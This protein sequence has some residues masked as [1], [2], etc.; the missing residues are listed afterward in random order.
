V[1]TSVTYD[2]TPSTDSAGIDYYQIQITNTQGYDEISSMPVPGFTFA[3]T[4]VYTQAV[5]HYARVRAIDGNGNIGPWSSTSAVVQSDLVPPV[6]RLPN[7]A[8]S[9]VYLYPSGLTL[10]YTNTMQFAESF[11]VR[12]LSEDNLSGLDR[13]TFSLAFGQV[14]GDDP[15]PVVFEGTYDVPNGSTE[16]GVISATVYDLVG[17]TSVQTYTYE[18]DAGLP[19]STPS[20]PAYYTNPS[21]P[22][23][24]TW[25]ATDT[26]SGVYSTTLWYMK[27]TTG[28]WQPYQTLYA[29]SGTF[30]FTPPAGDG[31]YLFAT[32]AADNVRNMEPGPVASETQTIYDTQVPQSQVTW[33]PQ[34]LNSSPITMTW[35]ATPFIASLVEVRLWYRVDGGDWQS[36]SIT[37]AQASGV[38][39]FTPSAGENAYHFGTVALDA[40]AKVEAQPVGTG[41]ATV[42]YDTSNAPP[43]GLAATPAGWTNSNDFALTW[44]NP[45]DLSGIAGAYYRLDT[46]PTYP[47]HGTR[48]D[49][50]DLEQ[51]TGVS[52]V[53]EGTHTAW[54]WLVDR[55]GNI[56]HTASSTAV[57]S[58]D[59]SI[60]AP[61]SLTPSPP[62]WTNVNS[63]AVEWTNPSDL[64][65][66]S[67]AYYKLYT[68]PTSPNDGT[69]VAG[70]DLAQ[71]SNVTLGTA[72][73]H[74]L[75]L[76][77]TDTAGNASHTMRQATTLRYD[78][79]P[80][81][82]LVVVAPSSTIETH[83]VVSWSASDTL[84]GIAWYTVEYSGT[85]YDDWQTW[86]VSTTATSAEFI[87]PATDVE[88]IFRV[89]AY[90]NA[91][92]STQEEA[93]T[94]VG[95]FYVYLPANIRYWA[96]WYQYDIYEP[97]DSPE[98]AYGPV[99]D[100][101]TYEAYIW[102]ATDQNDYY[103]FVSSTSDPVEVTLTNI[104]TGNDYDL[105]I[106][107]YT[108]KYHLIDFSNR[109]GNSNESVSFVP[110]PTTKYY[111]RVYS[112]SGANNQFPYRLR[113][114]YN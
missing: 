37:S 3:F 111:V 25:V 60:S 87:A 63:F 102:T 103:Y 79:V 85:L 4:E 43:T 83:F 90:D 11:D 108:D 10:Y 6:I 12:G 1:T 34:Y 46:A 5:G 98:Q 114:H 66:I 35:V 104:P 8:D 55:A 97:N 20:A 23:P 96:S 57:L 106:Y 21:T 7:L 17:N 22:I 73:A 52:V 93:T 69:W 59:A 44:A 15:F 31:L 110:T 16:N 53:G 92:N 30:D 112:Y 89:T 86:L 61:S 99:V 84:S 19:S 51:I 47:Q 100:G 101:A 70:S 94:R 109:T 2:W 41:D 32:V 81:A 113:V 75:Y 28:T 107:Y 105:Y 29:S 54:V 40:F 76:W 65:G 62:D 33:A 24:V 49:G 45:V 42:L 88:Y 18:L 38:F 39:T 77:L 78:P 68:P 56:D 48:I 50:D 67:G 71:I 36:T 27:E 64:S 58:Y 72:G 13:V 80:P 82:G 26:Q 9:S 91:G 74:W 14:P 95:F